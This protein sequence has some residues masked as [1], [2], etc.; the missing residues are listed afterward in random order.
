[1]KIYHQS[2]GQFSEAV[3]EL[4]EEEDWHVVE[5]EDTF[6]FQKNLEFIFD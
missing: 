2:S 5:N 1:M 3:I 6:G 4:I